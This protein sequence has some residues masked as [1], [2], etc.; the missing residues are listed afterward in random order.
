VTLNYSSGA[1]GHIEG[2]TS[3]TVNCGED[4]TQVTAVADDCYHFV[5]WSDGSTDNP[6]TDTDVVANVT[7]EASFSINTYTLTYTADGNGT[8]LGNPSQTVDCG[9]NGT[10]V[11]AVP[12]NPLAYHFVQ[13]L[14]DGSTANPRMDAYVTKDIAVEAMFAPCV[15]TSVTMDENTITANLDGVQ[16]SW[17]NPMPGLPVGEPVIPPVEEPYG[18][19]GNLTV[20]MDPNTITGFLNGEPIMTLPNPITGLPSG[21]PIS[22]P[23]NDLNSFCGTFQFKVGNETITTSIGNG[24]YTLSITD[25]CSSFTLNGVPINPNCVPIIPPAEGSPV[26]CADIA[27]TIDGNTITATLNGEPIALPIGGS[28]DNCGNITVNINGD[29]TITVSLNDGEPIVLPIDYLYYACASVTVDLGG[30]M[31]MTANYSNGSWAL[32]LIDGCRSVNF[33]GF[34]PPPPPCLVSVDVQPTDVDS[35]L[36]GDMQQFTATAFYSDSSYEDVTSTASWHCSRQDVADI[37]NTGLAK[38]AGAGITDVQATYNGVASDPATLVVNAVPANTLV[39][40][41]VRPGNAAIQVGG[42]QQFTAW[43]KYSYGTEVDVTTQAIWDSD[44]ASIATVS[45]GL[46]QGLTAGA[47]NMIATLQGESGAA[48][49]S[50]TAATPAEQP[51]NGTTPAAGPTVLTVVVEPDSATVAAGGTQQFTATAHYSDS[52]TADVTSKASWNSSKVDVATA[53]SSLA[54]G[55]APGACVI[56]AVYGNV[57]SNGA[58]LNVTAANVKPPV[59]RIVVAPGNATL[60]VG[61]T[62]QF[63]ATAYYSDGSSKDVTNEVTWASAKDGVATIDN[64]GL[65]TGKDVGDSEITASLQQVSSNPA[66]VSVVPVSVAWGMIGGIIAAV[67]IL[68]LL[69]L[70]LTRRGSK[71]QGAQKA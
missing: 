46:A 49:L 42:S 8:I 68:G 30:N 59:E 63:T 9:G 71:E 53:D 25:G 2:N 41:E 4:G 10:P 50:V 13:W 44:N 56:T 21:E 17:P 33:Q 66:P 6:R 28:S 24:G 54:T 47:T 23:I 35:I 22:L 64:A 45:S 60:S 38:G 67:L 18:I 39:S 36:I 37:D 62:Q 20:V 43:A 34:L 29:R 40:L 58:I 55:V 70:F 57:T 11:L 26:Y 1:N 7:A 61:G 3:Q 31:M 32:S 12:V 14:P 65:A 27:A 15:Y 19:C 69:F 5:G 51:G 52:T 48:A 16:M